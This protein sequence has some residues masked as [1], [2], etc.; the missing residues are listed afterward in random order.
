MEVWMQVITAFSS[1]GAILKS[2]TMDYTA[3]ADAIYNVIIS[4]LGLHTRYNYTNSI[5]DKVCSASQV[6]FISSM[7]QCWSCSS[8]DLD[9]QFCTIH[10]SKL[11]SGACRIGCLIEHLFFAVVCKPIVCCIYE[12]MPPKQ[13]LFV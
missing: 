12:Q 2:V 9:V 6:L 4:K 5:V 7:S 1:L 13:F 3:P 8:F 11:V 10:D